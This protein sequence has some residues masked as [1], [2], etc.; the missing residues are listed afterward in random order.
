MP[1]AARSTGLSMI[2]KLK[3]IIESMSRTEAII[4][5]NG[6]GYL[7]QCGLRTLS[8]LSQGRPANLHIETYVREDQLKLFAFAHEAERAWFVQ[9]QSVQGVG[10]R[11]ALAILDVLSV[12]DVHSA[13]LLGDGRVFEQAKGVGKKLA[14]RIITELKDKPG[15]VM[16]EFGNYQGTNDP[17][18]NT[19]LEDTP[20]DGGKPNNLI[21][22][23]MSAISALINLG[24]SEIDAQKAVTIAIRDFDTS[25]DEARVIKRALK[26]LA[27]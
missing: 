6:V 16:R 17:P 26:E 3:G 8:A 9:L 27:Q 20:N 2:G 18:I 25:A 14:Q 19:S 5:V 1:I 7:V 21:I 23:K 4:E 22:V 13:V 15:P 24:Y 10:A 12:K 11:H